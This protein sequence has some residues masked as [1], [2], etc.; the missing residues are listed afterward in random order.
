MPPPLAA[1]P[2]KPQ[3]LSLWPLY[4]EADS[5][6]APALLPPWDSLPRWL[7]SVAIILAVMAFGFFW[8]GLEGRWGDVVGKPDALGD[9]SGVELSSGPV[10]APF[11]GRPPSTM[12]PAA[13]NGTQTLADR[14]D[15]LV[16][17]WIQRAPRGNA[18]S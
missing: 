9:G 16:D 6:A 3:Q 12:E 1:P 18:A 17:R 8:I 2:S 14:A 4:R 10:P 15:L 5:P 11:S 13:P 7:E